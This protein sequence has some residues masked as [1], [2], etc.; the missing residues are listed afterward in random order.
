MKDIAQRVFNGEG[1]LSNYNKN[2]RPS[3]EPAIIL[4]VN[5]FKLFQKIKKYDYFYDKSL[6]CK[7][8]RAKT[9]LYSGKSFIF[10]TWESKVYNTAEELETFLTKNPDFHYV[11]YANSSK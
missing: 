8:V 10:S 6:F 9:D 7:L 4:K 1:F 5:P 11:E 2:F 3:T